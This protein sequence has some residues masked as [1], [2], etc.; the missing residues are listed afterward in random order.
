MNK[1]VRSREAL[2]NGYAEYRSWDELKKG[3]NVREQKKQKKKGNVLFLS[4]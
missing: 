3:Q 2:L 4:C 1:Q